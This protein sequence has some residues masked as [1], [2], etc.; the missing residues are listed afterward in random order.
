[1]CDVAGGSAWFRIQTEAEAV[2]EAEHMR[3]AA[4]K[5]FRRAFE[6]ASKTFDTT[7]MLYIE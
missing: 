2:R 6:A 1:V 5:H 4:E 3:H 7:G